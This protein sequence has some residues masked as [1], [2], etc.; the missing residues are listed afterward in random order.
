MDNTPSPDE[1]WAEV[2]RY[3]M[4]R[5]V[6]EDRALD[7]A[8]SASDEAGM[9]SHHVAPNQGKMLHLLARMQ[10]AESILEIGTLAGYSTIWLA[11]ALVPGGRVVSLEA[12]REHAAVAKA[13]IERA[14]V[15]DRVEVI[16]GP[17]ASSLRQLV[18]EEAG[19]FDLIFIDADKPSN[20]EY[21]KH[22]LE[23]SREGTLIV[24]DNVVRDGEVANAES[25]DPK[26]QGVR[27]FT[28]MLA[29][30]PRVTATAIQTVGCKGYDG[31]AM[32]L[33][34]DSG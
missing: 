9:P 31:F 34:T 15:A 27:R 23:L 29:E 4:D 13:N 25:D 12:D 28:D 3:F 16:V 33:V 5:L 1:T 21:L 32:A 24:A 20:P 22:S 17:A 14:G 2:D 26:V 11:R 19:P 7:E 6:S 10:C 18:S 8:I 30:D